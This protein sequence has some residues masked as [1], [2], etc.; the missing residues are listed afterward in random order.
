MLVLSRAEV[1]ELLDLDEL[2]AA[3]ARAHA[4]LSAGVVSLPPR[5]AALVGTCRRP[6]SAASS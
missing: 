6:G 1:E 4:E 3:L 2:L 5:I